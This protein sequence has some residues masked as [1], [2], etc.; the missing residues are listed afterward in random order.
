MTYI[1]ERSDWPRFTW[2]ASAIAARLGDA[3]HRQGRLLGRMS[4]IGLP[5][6]DEAV[7]SSLT[8]EAIKTSE[9]EG[10]TL[11]ADQVRSSV[12]RH[13][14]LETGGTL[15]I[16]RHVDGLVEMMMDAT[17]NHGALLTAERLQAWHG[18]LFPTGRSGLKRIRTAAWR[19]A[20]ADPMQVISGAAGR[21][22]VHFEAP[23]A[24]N[25]DS[26]VSAFLTWYNGAADMDG[27]SK[28]ALAH[29]WFVT[30]H[31]FEDGNGRIARA[32]AEMTLAR[33]ERSGRRFYSMSAQ[34]RSER[35]DYYDILEHTQKGDLDITPW[36]A[37]FLGCMERAIAH[38]ESTLAGVIARTRFW[39]HHAAEPFNARQRLMLIRL[40][41]GFEGKL[42]SSK[43]AKLGECSQDT[44]GRD[45]DDLVQRGILVKDAAGGRSTSYALKER[46]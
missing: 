36:M 27:V 1:N 40:L 15:R 2:D 25:L 26:E 18:A 9:I 30:L 7:L 3:R 6:Q 23:R 22:R 11:N 37:W 20:A 12:A 41:E 34:I 13:L 42:T 8:D 39:Q 46:S 24:E 45:I 38:A 17:Q 5:L 32:I 21:E 28:A 4:D 29:F 19:D 14:G 43:W 44:A 35:K 33:A 10:E 16:D 31:P